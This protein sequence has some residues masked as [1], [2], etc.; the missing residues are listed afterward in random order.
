MM[1]PPERAQRLLLE[2]I[3]SGC[4]ALLEK[5]FGLA[6]DYPGPYGRLP[7]EIC[8]KFLVK[9]PIWFMRGWATHLIMQ[10]EEEGPARLMEI[11]A[12][13]GGAERVAAALR[14]ARDG[15]GDWPQKAMA[16][17][18]RKLMGGRRPSFHPWTLYDRRSWG[19]AGLYA[20]VWKM[21][22]ECPEEAGP[23]VESLYRGGPPQLKKA[24]VRI[25]ARQRKEAFLPELRKCLGSGKPRQGEVACEAFWEMH[26]MGEAAEPTAAQMLESDDWLQRKAAVCLLRRWG[27]LTQAQRRKAQ[28]DEHV[29]VRQ[30]AA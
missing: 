24:A 1:G 9:T 20:N 28:Q 12:G 14:L 23:L 25:L 17:L 5:A 15:D 22:R 30:A 19:N 4:N 11:A 8:E 26:R 6:T 10:S 27:K 29:A 13:D 16:L 7:Q 18:D 3:D 2:A 21:A